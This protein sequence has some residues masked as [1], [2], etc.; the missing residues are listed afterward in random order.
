MR[1]TIHTE[2]IRPVTL[3]EFLDFR[4]ALSVSSVGIGANE[5]GILTAMEDSIRN[6]EIL[7]GAFVN[8]QLLGM[9]EYSEEIF[10]TNSQDHVKELLIGTIFVH[11]QYRDQGTGKELVNFVLEQANTDYVLTDPIDRRAESFF[12]QCGFTQ[13]E[14][15]DKDQVG[16][17]MMVHSKAHTREQFNRI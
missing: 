7:Y 4:Y 13:N 3:E 9:V 15:F 8:G 17:W 12:L 6:G 10:C 2:K 16:T 1:P 14:I 11:P 5:Q